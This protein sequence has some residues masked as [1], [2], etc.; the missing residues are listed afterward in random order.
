MLNSHEDASPSFFHPRDW[1]G[2]RYYTTQ[3]KLRPCGSLAR[4]EVVSGPHGSFLCPPFLRCPDASLP[5][6]VHLYSVVLGASLLL[7]LPYAA[8]RLTR[9]AVHIVELG[10]SRSAGGDHG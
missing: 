10:A 4:G 1:H 8:C 3:R 5:L 6:C 9:G 7:L 2:A